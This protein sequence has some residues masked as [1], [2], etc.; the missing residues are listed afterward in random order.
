MKSLIVT[1]RATRF[2]TA[3]G[4]REPARQYAWLLTFERMLADS[5][6]VLSGQQVAALTRQQAAFDLL[7]KAEALLGSSPD[8][9]GNG[10]K[11]LLRQ[12]DAMPLLRRS[13]SGLPDSFPERFAAFAKHLY[14]RYG[15]A[16]LI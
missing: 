8:A 13:V 5:L 14:V 3:L 1:R 10:F 15:G 12:T 2:V 6:I 11:R 9:T 16:S 4:V 7:D